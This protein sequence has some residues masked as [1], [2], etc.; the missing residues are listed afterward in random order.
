M[1]GVVSSKRQ[2]GITLVELLVVMS[3]LLVVTTMII[4]TW[5]ALTNAYSFTSR[6]DKQRDLARQA[7]DRM[8]REIR[9]AQEPLGTSSPAI[10][11]AYP[12]EIRFYS[13]F[14][15]AGASSPTTEPRLTRFI[16]RVTNATDGIG[17]VYREFP[18]PDGDFDTANDN[19]SQLLVSDVSN[20]DAGKDVFTYRSYDPATSD[21]VD[22][23]GMTKLADPSRVV[24]VGICLLVDLNPGK[25]PNYMDVTT[26][27]QPRNVRE[28]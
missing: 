24:E 28:F 22:S 9:D 23:D 6:S 18:G 15:T 19:V 3:I 21:L 10:N 27:V 7:I 12:N 11:L 16:Y 2:K 25:A 8:A 26:T 1:I 13:T 14:N 5:V 4:G 20:G 17:A